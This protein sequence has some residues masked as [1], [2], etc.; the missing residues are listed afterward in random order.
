M[1]TIDDQ[2]LLIINLFVL[3][4]IAGPIGIE[5]VFIDSAEY[6]DYLRVWRLLESMEIT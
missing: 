4:V 2:P 1:F 3:L 5:P 6:G